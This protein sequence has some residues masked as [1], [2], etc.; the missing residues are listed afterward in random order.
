M[1][2]K[3]ENIFLDIFNE[4]AEFK[5]IIIV[6]YKCAINFATLLDLI[7]EKEFECARTG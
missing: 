3:M 2:R 5:N 6:I 7:S 4:Y 1:T